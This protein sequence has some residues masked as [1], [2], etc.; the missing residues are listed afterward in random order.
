MYNGLSRLEELADRTCEDIEFARR[1]IYKGLSEVNPFDEMVYKCDAL[2][3]MLRR[4]EV[5]Y[6]VLSGDLVEK[7]RRRLKIE[8]ENCPDVRELYKSSGLL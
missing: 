6:G 4:F 1:F 7:L 8:L 2:A 3:S 5:V